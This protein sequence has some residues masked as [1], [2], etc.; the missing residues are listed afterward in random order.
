MKRCAK[1][2]DAALI[3]YI[4]AFALISPSIVLVGDVKKNRL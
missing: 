4:P 2:P 3:V 1:P